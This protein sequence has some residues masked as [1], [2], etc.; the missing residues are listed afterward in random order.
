MP[1]A[2]RAVFEAVNHSKGQGCSDCRDYSDTEGVLNT[3]CVFSTGCLWEHPLFVLMGY[4]RQVL[5]VHVSCYSNVCLL[6]KKE[7]SYSCL[8]SRQDFFLLAYN[9]K[10]SCKSIDMNYSSS[11]F[12]FYFIQQKGF[13]PLN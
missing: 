2:L 1:Y 9:F 4:Y 12:F 10:W 5:S 8:G 11:L 13:R 6:R 3:A 7:N